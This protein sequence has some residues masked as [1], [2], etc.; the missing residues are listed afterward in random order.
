[1]LILITLIGCDQKVID[2]SLLDGK[3]EAAAGYEDGEIKGEPNCYPFQEGIEFKDDSKVYIQTYER[4]FKYLVYSDDQ[5]I[6]FYDKKSSIY[7]YKIKMPSNEEVVLEGLGF[8]ESD[9]CYLKKK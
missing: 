5:E 2:E 8:H 1:M 6:F 3:W 7:T 4:D 9:A